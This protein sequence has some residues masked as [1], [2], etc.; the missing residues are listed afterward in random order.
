[1]LGL[2]IWSTLDPTNTFAPPAAIPWIIA[3]A[4]AG[5]IWGF[6]PNGRK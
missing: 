4:Y 3:F 2:L 1:M 5:V 6:A